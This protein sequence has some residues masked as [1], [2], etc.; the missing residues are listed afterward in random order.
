MGYVL[1]SNNRIVLSCCDVAGYDSVVKF[2][3]TVPEIKFWMTRAMW[4][5][6]LWCSEEERSRYTQVSD[7]S[8]PYIF[9]LPRT[10]EF[11]RNAL[12]MNRYVWTWLVLA[13]YNP[14]PTLQIPRQGTRQSHQSHFPAPCFYFINNKINLN[15]ESDFP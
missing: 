4:E 3:N 2:W 8:R 1:Q 14:T 9:V 10:P 5:K 13:Q 11:N 6:F 12:L 7:W 15:R